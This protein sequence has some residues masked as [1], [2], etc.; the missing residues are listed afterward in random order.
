MSYINNTSFTN[1]M[2]ISIIKN[3]KSI[4]NKKNDYDED[5]DIIIHKANKLIIEKYQIKTFYINEHINKET[6]EVNSNLIY[7]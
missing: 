7:D 6:G 5:L 4:D 2:P 3:E 1:N